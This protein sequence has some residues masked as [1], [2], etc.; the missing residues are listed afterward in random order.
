MEIRY[1]S[2]T[3]F[4][5][6]TEFIRVASCSSARTFLLQSH[7]SKN[8]VW[9][10]NILMFMLH[11]LYFTRQF[12]QYMKVFHVVLWLHNIRFSY[13]YV[14]LLMATEIRISCAYLRL[15]CGYRTERISRSATIECFYFLCTI[16]VVLL[17]QNIH[18]S[19]V[20]FKLFCGYRIFLFLKYISICSV[21]TEH[22]YPYVYF[23]LFCG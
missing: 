8:R 20:H 3:A 5:P 17:L 11:C 22:F 15:F 16:H 10:I 21:A 19:Y 7:N 14:M 12:S 18:I 9:S 2:F 1:S 13:V 23:T 4:F 6:C